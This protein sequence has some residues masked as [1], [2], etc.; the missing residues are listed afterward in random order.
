[1]A[2]AR[3]KEPTI[4][5]Q[6]DAAIAREGNAPVFVAAMA[7][8]WL[9]PFEQKLPFRL[10]PT[11]RSLLLRYRFPCFEVGSVSLFGNVDGLSRD[12]L[13]VASIRDRWLTPVM[14]ADGFIQIGRPD[15][16]DYDPICFD[17]R[18]RTK[19]G[20]GRIVQLDHEEIL[21]NERTRI[22]Q[23][24]ADSFLDLLARGVRFYQE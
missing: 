21:C 16:G 17:M 1:M 8:P 22:V 6:V 14:H 9:A 15:T 3:K 19:S 23:N 5:E 13:V 24:V 20:E 12:E 2:T 7:P 18:R 11:Y 4:D 10:P